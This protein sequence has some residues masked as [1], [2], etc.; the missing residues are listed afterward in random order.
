[1]EEKNETY[2]IDLKGDTLTDAVEVLADNIEASNSDTVVTDAIEELNDAVEAIDE[3]E[4]LTEK[5]KKEIYIEQL[6]ASVYR[7]HPIKHKGNTTT[8]RFGASAKKNRQKRNKLR[9]KANQ[10]NRK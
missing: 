7:H 8:N 2:K 5:E 6:K 1:M 10:R 4:E 9:K 3:V